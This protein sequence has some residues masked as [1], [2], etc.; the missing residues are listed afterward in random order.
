[1]HGSRQDRLCISACVLVVTAGCGGGGTGPLVEPPPAVDSVHVFVDGFPAQRI[2][3]GNGTTRQGVRLG[4]KLFYDRILSGDDTQSCG[5][6]H[7]QAFGFTDNGRRFSLGIDGIFGTR[8][9]P[10]LANIGWRTS[11]FWDGR[12][13]TLEDQALGPVPNPIEMHQEWNVAVAKLQA[14]AEYPQLFW[15][16]FGTRTIT[17]SLVVRAIAQF[18]RTIVSADSRYDRYLRRHATR[19]PEEERGYVVFFFERGDCFH[20]HVNYTFTDEAFHNNGLDPAYTD[21]GLGGITGLANDMGKFK[22]PSLRNVEF[23]APYMHDGRFAT[24]E[25]VIEHYDSGG[26]GTPT[27]DP[28]IRVGRGLGLTVQEKSD[29]LA[30]LKSLSDSTFLVNPEYGAPP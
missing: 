27:V 7:A 23:T 15:E 4:R 17:S 18:E 2:P 11:L 13:A 12:A 28:F 20:C 16:A 5:D 3:A 14:R 29:L 26:F 21:L 8:S 6:C 24:L 30:F 10:S 22:T 1:M 9:A 25:Q 19:T